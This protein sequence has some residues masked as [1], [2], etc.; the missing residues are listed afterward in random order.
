ML[1]VNFSNQLGAGPRKIALK[2]SE[3]VIE[4]RVKSCIIIPNISEFAHLQST[5]DVVFVRVPWSRNFI[6]RII[7]RIVWLVYYNMVLH[8]FILEFGNYSMFPFHRGC[9][10]VHHPYL[11]DD[12]AYN[13]LS[14][15]S[16]F[17]EAVKRSMLK[18]LSF[19][20]KKSIVVQSEVIQIALAKKYN[21]D[22]SVIPNP[23]MF[24]ADEGSVRQY[25]KFSANEEIVCIYASRYYPHKDHKLAIDIVKKLRE[26]Y[27]VKL[28]VTVNE[29]DIPRHVKLLLGQSFVENVGEVSQAKLSQLYSTSH[30]AIFPSQT[31]T[32]GNTIAEK[33]AFG[34]PV[35][36][37][38][39]SY[40]HA[41]FTSDELLVCSF[42]D[43]E[44]GVRVF[45]K[46]LDD[47]MLLNSISQMNYAK[48][49][50][51]MT[52]EMWVNAYLDLC[53]YED[54]AARN[55]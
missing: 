7:L 34:L 49:N 33:M 39:A 37:R 43:I 47:P 54:G 31:E 13:S 22:S 44:S 53:K 38:D 46:L 11:Y 15:K 21:I 27:N 32:Y 3:Y 25:P 50:D 16:K 12:N 9:V 17:I 14:L 19:R 23:I 36:I 35:V 40:A 6:V 28:L 5:V 24:R 51:F 55:L 8:G 52:T 26:Y 41:F 29:N 30:I 42:K 18:L 4:K 48:S 1:I 2:F 45:R 20:N 10:L